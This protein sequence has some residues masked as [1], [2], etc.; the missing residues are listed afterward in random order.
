MGAAPMRQSPIALPRALSPDTP[1]DA[2]H[3]IPYAGGVARDGSRVY[4][5][6]RIPA[7]VHVEGKPIDVHSA[8][9]LHERTEFPLMHA[10]GMHYADAHQI[11]TAVENHFIRSHYGVDPKKYQDSLRSSIGSARQSGEVEPEDL[12]PKPY[13][14]S[15]ETHLLRAHHG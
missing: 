11:A 4:I 15:G 12:D 1:I 9:A 13:A 10:M 8:V 2:S 7:V 6:K 5:D 3:S 14:D